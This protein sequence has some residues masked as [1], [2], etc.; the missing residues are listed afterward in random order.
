[1]TLNL[2]GKL[3]KTQTAAVDAAVTRYQQFIKD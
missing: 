3:N 1:M 2:F